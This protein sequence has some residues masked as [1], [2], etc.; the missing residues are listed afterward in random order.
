MGCWGMGLAQSDEYCEIYERF[1]ECYD[2]G[3]EVSEITEEILAEY[4]SEFEEDDGI[5]HDVYFALAKAQWMCWQLS[6]ALLERITQIIHS[7][8]PT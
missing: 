2:E 6:P 4:L 3:M 1:M 7:G 8:V 5:L